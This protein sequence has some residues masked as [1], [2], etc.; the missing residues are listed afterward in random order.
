MK[1][2]DKLDKKKKKIL[3]FSILILIGI[4]Y[5]FFLGE[6]GYI[7][8]A[9]SMTYI[10]TE[11]REYRVYI[12]F[13]D[14][15]ELIFGSSSYLEVVNILQGIFALSVSLIVTIYIQ[16]RFRLKEIEAL[17][18]YVATFLPYGYSLPQSV[19]THHILTEGLSYTFF[20]LF[21]LF[22]FI[23]FLDKKLYMM[24]PAA[25][26]LVLLIGTRSQ[27]ML[28]AV[29][30]ITLWIVLGL[31]WLYG[32]IQGNAKKIFWIIL[33]TVTI[34]IC[35][36]IPFM[37][38]MMMRSGAIPQFV[39]AMSG[40]ALCA[41]EENDID[42]MDEKYKDVARYVYEQIDEAGYRE[43]YFRTDLW[44]WEDI[45]NSTN[46]NT[47]GLSVWAFEYC[48]KEGIDPNQI[49]EIRYYLT[50]YLFDRHMDSYL[51]MTIV[52]CIQSFVAS[53]FIH[54]DVI[55]TLCH[56]VALGIYLSAIVLLLI[57]KRLKASVCARIPL[58]LTGFTLV[59]NVIITNLFFFGQ[60]R[61]VVYTFGFFYIAVYILLRDIIVNCKN[62]IK[63]EERN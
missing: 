30:Y 8:E 22:L 2:I 9:D 47:I 21:L 6:R 18:V 45:L 57:S 59:A 23:V 51:E 24:I 3:F 32:K 4:F 43:E 28:L 29:V 63:I 1:R 27:L 34:S 49:A 61:Y 58:L 25:V 26:M 37:M 20:H 42:S 62:T 38:K 19:A 53:V 36:M 40:R 17:L 48:D 44:R 39:S 50:E 14:I 41:I 10:T 52:L 7:L 11:L 46:E 13:L 54:P 35:S 15:C 5:F 31:Q 16:N 33:F 55:Y 56:I 12:S 60:Q